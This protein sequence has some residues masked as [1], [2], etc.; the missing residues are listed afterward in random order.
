MTEVKKIV[1]YLVTW[2]DNTIMWE[3]MDEEVFL[4]LLLINDLKYLFYF[5][6]NDTGETI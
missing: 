4:Q 2:V 5:F 6:K 1:Q 3:P